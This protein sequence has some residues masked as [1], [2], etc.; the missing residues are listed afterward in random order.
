MGSSVSQDL[1][2]QR[3]HDKVQDTRMMLDIILKYML[4]EITVRDFMALS[5]PSECKKYVL[6][7]AN[8][9][10]KHFYELQIFPEKSKG[11]FIVFRKADELVGSSSDQEKQSLCLILS[12]YYTR[13]FQI[14]GALALTL[15][16]DVNFMTSTGLTDLAKE[17]LYTPGNPLFQRIQ[18]GS[19]GGVNELRMYE[20]MR[21][22]IEKINDTY[23]QD[24]RG[25]KLQYSGIESTK[26]NVYFQLKEG[27]SEQKGVFLFEYA[28]A[29]NRYYL[30]V[31]LTPEIGRDDFT[32]SLRDI[33]FKEGNSNKQISIDYEYP[34]SQKLVRA[35]DKYVIDREDFKIVLNRQFSKIINSLQTYDKIKKV[36]TTVRNEREETGTVEELRLHRIIRNLTGVKPLG[37]CVARALQLLRAQPIVNQ[38]GVS[39]I[40]K[41]K[42]LETGKGTSR[43]GI[44]DRGESIDTSPG[45][46]SLA[47]LFYDTINVGTPKLIIGNK[48]R[49]DSNETSLEQYVKFMKL[50]AIR[51][52][53]NKVGDKE[54]EMDPK[55]GLKGIKNRRDERLCENQPDNIYIPS[56]A[57]QKVF[58]IVKDL[59][60]IQ[61]IHA[62][63]CGKILNML[64]NI[65]RDPAGRI[66]VALSKNILEKGFPEIDRINHIARDQLIKYYSN[67]EYRYV[68]GMKIVLDSKEDPKQRVV[69]ADPGG[70]NI[71]NVLRQ[72]GITQKRRN[73][74]PQRERRWFEPA[75]PQTSYVAPFQAPMQQ[76]QQAQAQQAQM[77]QVQAQQAQMQQAPMQQ[78][79]MQQAQAQMQQAQ[80][81]RMQ[82]ARMQQARMQQAQQPRA[83]TSASAYVAQNP[84]RAVRF[85]T[86]PVPQRAPQ[87][88][89]RAPVS[90][91]APTVF[92]SAPPPSQYATLLRAPAVR[93]PSAPV[94]T[95]APSAPSAF[96][97]VPAVKAPAPLSAVRAP[98]AFAAPS[99]NPSPV[100]GRT[101][102]I[103]PVMY[104]NERTNFA[105]MIK[106]N[107]MTK[108]FIYNENF[109]A[110]GAGAPNKGDGNAIIRPYRQDIKNPRSDGYAL[111]IPTGVAASESTGNKIQTTPLRYEP[112][113]IIFP[114]DP[115]SIL[116]YNGLF[117][118]SLENIHAFLLSHPAITDVYYSSDSTSTNP[119]TLSF[120]IFNGTVSPWTNPNKAAMNA[121]FNQCIQTIKTIYN[122]VPVNI[123][124]L[125][126]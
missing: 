56:D 46:S 33:Y 15:I 121:L 102:R 92:S 78:A 101:I 62:E 94:R 54:R 1:T 32:L 69:T 109:T 3:V 2:R 74:R 53:D 5:N 75:A 9:L 119:A 97:P 80:Q 60:K 22:Y 114:Y 40:C 65:T 89:Q 16:D 21:P 99:A 12:Y 49:Q 36:N 123:T 118:T 95:S 91:P 85:S 27:D 117:C 113:F 41:T 45:L 35:N 29:K 115:L 14:Y 23:V 34:K 59:F 57:S 24:Y 52:G 100:T 106:D 87:A 63:A 7:M 66:R 26:G 31:S 83:P 71:I 51:F 77:Q 44:P 17:R 30:N 104:T 39:Y 126:S 73:E 76:V 47:L 122:T 81:A 8:D 105:N 93:A 111:G 61:E 37:H 68:E 90:A 98:S 38:Q 64:F 48:K 25:Y 120:D 124:I 116:N 58:D 50:M 84:A 55:V 110:Y 82:Q 4:Q 72:R 107:P 70:R 43:S 112:T 19:M 108:L 28:G 125:Q 13:I 96:S 67:C 86:T 88:P 18:G 42:F 79:Q 10:Y 11:S 20:F 103:H 6:F